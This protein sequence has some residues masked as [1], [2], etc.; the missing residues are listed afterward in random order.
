MTGKTIDE[1]KNNFKKELFQAFD[2]HKCRA[3]SSVSPQQERRIRNPFVFEQ[4]DQLRSK[5][6]FC[7]WLRK[8]L[9]H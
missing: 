8:R 3:R 7:F 9:P 6:A 4:V 1:M 2:S 5:G